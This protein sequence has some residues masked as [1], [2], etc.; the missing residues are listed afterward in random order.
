MPEQ[1]RTTPLS[2]LFPWLAP[3]VITCELVPGGVEVQLYQHNQALQNWQPSKLRHVLPEQLIEWM[4]R[5]HFHQS[6]QPYPLVQQ[7]WYYLTPHAS[8]KL[9]IDFSRL[10]ELREGSQPENFALVW[11][12]NHEEERIEGYFEGA[13]HYLGQGW[14]HAGNTLW[15]LSTPPPTEIDKYLRYPVLPL[16]QAHLLFTT[17][18]LQLLPYLSTRADFRLIF[19]CSF[20]ITAPI[21]Q[22]DKLVLELACNHPDL[23][24]TLS[25]PRQQGDFLLADR[26]IIQFPRQAL[27][28][29]L[30][31]LFHN[32][33]SLTLRG[34]DIPLFIREQLPIMR[35]SRQVAPE[36]ADQIAEV[37]PVVSLATLQPTPSYTH[38]YVNGIGTYRITTTYQHQGQVL[39]ASG[40]LTA[41]QRQQRFVRQGDTWFEWPEQRSFELVR[42]LQQQ[43]STTP[44]RPEEVMGFDTQRIARLEHPL[45]VHIA[46]SPGVTPAERAQPLFQLLRKHG[47]PGGILGEAAGTAKM[48]VDAC[49]QLVRDNRQASILWL[50]PS[51]KKGSVTRTVNSS[52]VGTA[53]TVA[54]LITLRDEP[55]LFAHPWTLLIFQELDHL[56]DGSIQARRLSQL[57][58]QWALASVISPTVVKPSI[59]PILH[60]PQ[61]YC[62]PFCARFLFDVSKRYPA[63]PASTRTVDQPSVTVRPQEERGTF[64]QTAPPFPPV[65]Q[66]PQPHTIPTGVTARQE[67]VM[68]PQHRVEG[69][70]AAAQRRFEDQRA[71]AAQ[72]TTS[73]AS[74]SSTTARP[75]EDSSPI[76][77]VI[78]LNQQKIVQLHE[79]SERLRER[80][81]VEEEGQFTDPSLPQVDISV[82]QSV[83]QTPLPTM[84]ALVSSPGQLE[85]EDTVKVPAYRS[86]AARTITHDLPVPTGIGK[87][88]QG[89]TATPVLQPIAKLDL[90]LISKLQ[91]DTMSL[92]ERL[93]DESEG[94][95]IEQDTA[96]ALSAL[97]ATAKPAPVVDE[98]WRVIAHHWNAEHWEMIVALDQGQSNQLP[99]IARKVH[100]PLSQLIDEINTPVAE[101]LEDWLIEPETLTFASHF[102]TDIEELIQWYTSVS[103]NR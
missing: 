90:G 46:L 92:Q 39:D 63:E 20:Q 59:M 35:Q 84:P 82:S 93:V 83:P 18:L 12:L 43:Q 71:R 72:R 87:P 62:E 24:E 14:F 76:Q 53:V 44:L 51:N 101:Q 45:S 50:V 98:D 36:I 64:A 77:R 85:E 57:R 66:A 49:E 28:P 56:L 91:A 73:P 6:P 8:K 74:D 68:D 34:A 94:D 97:I 19:G 102:L 42:T 60:L 27:T 25:I 38:T 70:K 21:L 88:E 1:V 81:I 61:H 52:F 41:H 54:S 15:S 10:A 16:E 30:T 75:G 3:L 40:L 26:A 58:W 4:E 29:V 65:T 80:L 96:L 17:I 37:Y 78:A 7:L 32:K 31:R 33:T 99:V 95:E 69:Y 47:I 86:H 9:I 67:L 55:A 103:C 22:G 23:L 11:W 79:E 89:I 2:L 5:H 48:F 100:R 13:D